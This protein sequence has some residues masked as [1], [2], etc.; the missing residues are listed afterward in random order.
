M[1]KVIYQTFKHYYD[2]MEQFTNE[3]EAIKECDICFAGDSII[4]MFDVSNFGNYKAINR[5]IVSDKSQGLLMSLDD[6]VVAINPRN[7]FIFI[8]SNDICDGYTLKQIENN[9]LDIIHYLKEK[10]PKTNIILSTITPPCYYIADHVDQIYP[11][12]RDINRIEGLNEIIKTIGKKENIVIADVYN[13]LADENKSL[14]VDE[15][16]DGVHLT[17]GAYNKIKD[18]ILPLFK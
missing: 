8:G 2:R 13:L 18:Y 4:E 11:E 6:R 9:Y 7:I 1:E 10:L 3:N 14:R 16:L 12:C 17:T 5:G 15:T